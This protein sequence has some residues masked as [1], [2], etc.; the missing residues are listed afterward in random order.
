MNGGIEIRQV[1][2]PKD[3]RSQ[4][5]ELAHSSL[6]GGHMGIRKTSDRVLSKFF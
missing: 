6:V 4:V 5:I 3:L 2:V 1:V